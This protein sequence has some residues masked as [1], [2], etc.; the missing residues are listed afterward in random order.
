MFSFPFYFPFSWTTFFFPSLTFISPFFS[1]LFISFMFFFRR[2]YFLLPVSSHLFLPFLSLPSPLH[3]S[4]SIFS[5]LPFPFLVCLFIPFPLYFFFFSLFNFLSSSY[6]FYF[7]FP[8]H[9]QLKGKVG[10]IICHTLGYRHFPN[11]KA[12]KT[13]RKK[14]FPVSLETFEIK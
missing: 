6:I 5:F 14:L 9:F 11:Y 1:S 12:E 3:S 2:V 8:F 4:F 13:G 10:H 7:L